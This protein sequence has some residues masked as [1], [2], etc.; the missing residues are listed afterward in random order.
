MEQ[1]YKVESFSQPTVESGAHEH[2]NLSTLAP[3][4]TKALYN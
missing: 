4:P 1:R 3:A 2:R